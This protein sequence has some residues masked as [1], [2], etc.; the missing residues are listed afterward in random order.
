MKAYKLGLSTVVLQFTDI[1]V[2][3]LNYPK[4]LLIGDLVFMDHATKPGDM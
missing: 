1:S 4:K 2:R 3:L